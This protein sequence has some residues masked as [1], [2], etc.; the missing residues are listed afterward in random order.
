MD[1]GSLLAE[2]SSL[3]DAFID[4]GPKEVTSENLLARKPRSW[5]DFLDANPVQKLL[6]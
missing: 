3:T 5:S 4:Y 1:V 6:A 2:I